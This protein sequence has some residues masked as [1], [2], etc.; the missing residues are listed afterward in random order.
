MDD[1]ILRA[2]I[3]GILVVAVA[4]PIG[5][6]VVWRR[7]AYFGDTLAHSA[8]LGTALALI[9]DLEP[10]LGVFLI[11]FLMST[12]LIVFQRKPE[13]SL[14]TLLGIF[15][16]GSLALGLIL[17]AYMQKQGA[18]VDLMAY[19]FGDILAVNT[20]DLVWMLAGVM[21]VAICLLYLWRD[22]LAIAIHE[23]LARSEGV[24]VDRIRLLFMLLMTLVVAV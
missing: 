8:L 1:F 13:L 6:V 3:A 24:A 22:F 14:D 2:L 16:H 7:M 5:C 20:T 21:L 23:E 12:L 9:T 17:L 11:G 19:L 15:S 18:R 4:A 10:M